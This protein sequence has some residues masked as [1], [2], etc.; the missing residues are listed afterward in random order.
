MN[1]KLRKIGAPRPAAKH[2]TPSK[3]YVGAVP[4][5]NSID[6]PDIKKMSN[7]AQQNYGTFR[8]GY[9]QAKSSSGVQLGPGAY[10]LSTLSNVPYVSFRGAPR[11]EKTFSWGETIIVREGETVTVWNESYHPGDIVINGG[12]DYATIPR[13][14]TVPVYLNWTAS[15]IGGLP[16]LTPANPCDARRAK[17]V[18]IALAAQ[19]VTTSNGNLGKVGKPQERS[20]FTEVPV[21]IKN[22]IGAGYFSNEIVAAGTALTMIPLGYQS[23][24]G[25]DSSTMCLLDTAEFI[26]TNIA[27]GAQLN[28]AYYV[29]EY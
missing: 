13:R 11:Q 5:F 10:S 17:G 6:M 7:N 19:V 12:Q 2:I 1:D 20:H 4:R 21:V 15:G 25:D 29:I 9:V 24:M 28:M 14:I 23:N 18:W 16:T 8:C 3:P 27:D 26:F 22:L